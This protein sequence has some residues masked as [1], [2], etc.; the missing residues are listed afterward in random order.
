M[1]RQESNGGRRSATR[2]F[3]FGFEGREVWFSGSPESA[4]KFSAFFAGVLS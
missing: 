4:V 3:H 2:I 1:K